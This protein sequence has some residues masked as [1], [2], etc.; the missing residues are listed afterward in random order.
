MSSIAYDLQF[1]REALN[2]LENYLLSKEIFWSVPINPPPGEPAYP[3]ISLGG[4]LLSQARLEAQMLSQ[5]IT[6][7]QVADS[8]EVITRVRT[9]RS[10][11][12]TACEKKASLSLHARTTQWGNFL[13]EY[14][15]NPE[16]NANRYPYEVRLR[17]ILDLL[18]AEVVAIPPEQKSHLEALDYILRQSWQPGPFIW[19]NPLQ[20]GFPANRFWYLY[21]TLKTTG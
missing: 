19:A 17:V 3:A 16:G 15:A 8:Q 6:P 12:R 21:G 7:D 4:I 2:I 1:L 20:R 11:W 5:E 14:R 10:Q 13:E 9:L 18:A